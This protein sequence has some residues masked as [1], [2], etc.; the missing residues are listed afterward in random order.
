MID[1]FDETDLPL[2]ATYLDAFM[3]VEGAAALQA[4]VDDQPWQSTLR[5]RVQHYGWRYD[6]QNRRSGPRDFI[7]PLPDILNQLGHQVAAHFSLPHAFNQ[8]I[9]N[10][11]LPGQ[12]ISAHMDCVRS[13]GPTIVSLSLGSSCTMVFSNPKSGQTRQCR[14]HPRSLLMLQGE[15]RSVWTH[16]IAPRKTDTVQGLTLPRNRRVSI[17]L[18]CVQP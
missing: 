3:S 15:A 9:V 6:Y 13:F 10:E 17:T 8:A 5:R 12:G 2:G 11:Y 1:L 16:G 18:R 4:F 7:G 14:L